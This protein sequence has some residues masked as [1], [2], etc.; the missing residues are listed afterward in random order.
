MATNKILTGIQFLYL[1][2]FVILIFSPLFGPWAERVGKLAGTAFLMIFT[3]I[4]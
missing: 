4:G 3:K 2:S 1:A